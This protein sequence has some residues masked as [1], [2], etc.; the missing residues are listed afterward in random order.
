MFRSIL[1]TSRPVLLLVACLFVRTSVLAAELVITP[2]VQPVEDYPSGAP[3]PSAQNAPSSKD[4]STISVNWLNRVIATEYRRSHPKEE[5]VAL[6]LDDAARYFKSAQEQ[7]RVQLNARGEELERMGC[8]DPGFQLMAGIVQKDAKKKENLLRLAIAGFPRTG[9]ARFLIVMAATNLGK[10]LQDRK[11]DA[12]EISEADRIAL[13]ALRNGLDAESFHENEMTALRFRLCSESTESLLRRRPLEVVEV[14][15]Q[16]TNLPAW[17]R[18]LGQGRGYARAA[19]VARTD[20]WSSEVTEVG[21][22]G[23]RQ[24]LAKAR[25]HFTKAWELNPKDPAAAAYMIEVTMGDSG[26]K[27]EMRRWFDRAVAAEM[28]CWEAYRSLMWALRPRW[29]GSHEEMLQFGDE[30][31]RTGRFDTCVPHYYQMIVD[32]ISEEEQDHR[33]IY[34]RPEIIRNYKLALTRYLD[35]PD[36]PVVASYAYTT[37]AILDYQEGNLSGA[38]THM[39]AIQLQPSRIVG[40]GLRED[41]PKMMKAL[42]P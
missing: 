13:E 38:R 6:F 1:I 26:N 11:G 20:G 30:C 12:Q 28:D 24:N 7:V 3:I 27:Q 9:Y 23:W 31:L 40:A 15:K 36:M 22:E 18:E 4:F 19:W 25:E 32:D 16:A 8:T 39:E 37:A 33:A 42:F 2:S 10:S 5:N 21:W 29:H 14:F 35:T 34:Q 41:L 17:I